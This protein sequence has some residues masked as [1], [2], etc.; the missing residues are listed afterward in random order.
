[1]SSKLDKVLLTSTGVLKAV[2]KNEFVGPPLPPASPQDQKMV[3][4][5][6]APPVS[7]ENDTGA[8][9]ALQERVPLSLMMMA[10]L[11]EGII[12]MRY[13]PH[14]GQVRSQ[15]FEQGDSGNVGIGFFPAELL[16]ETGAYDG[17]LDVYDNPDYFDA[18]QE[19]L[20]DLDQFCIDTDVTIHFDACGFL[21]PDKMELFTVLSR[22]LSSEEFR[23]GTVDSSMLVDDDFDPQFIEQ[24]RAERTA[25]LAAD[26]RK[27]YD[28][29]ERERDLT[30][31]D[32]LYAVNNQAYATKKDFEAATYVASF[33]PLPISLAHI[34]TTIC[35]EDG[36][37]QKD[38]EHILVGQAPTLG[39]YN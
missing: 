22:Y 24:Q 28:K 12:N 1:M 6:P 5:P 21:S 8:S 14:T 32:P 3:P 23:M 2:A 36:L 13:A 7:P 25:K 29:L 26:G 20:T 31:C 16:D 37:D 11:F 35:Q 27:M 34:K 38:Y 18:M 39:G 15:P 33:A 10:G 4:A 17:V 30:A 9:P 19:F